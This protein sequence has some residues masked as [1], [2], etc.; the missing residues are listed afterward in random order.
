MWKWC[1]DSTS[2]I[3]CTARLR[4]RHHRPLM[5]RRDGVASGFYLRRVFGRDGSALLSIV[6]AART[7]PQLGLE[8]ANAILQLCGAH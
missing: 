4:Q 7:D 6:D 1:L 2:A 3:I 5:A 8:G